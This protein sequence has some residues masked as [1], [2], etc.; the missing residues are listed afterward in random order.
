M[1]SERAP[2]I[3][4]AKA[5]GANVRSECIAKLRSDFRA[6]SHPA[7][8]ASG[9]YPKRPD[10]ASSMGKMTQVTLFGSRKPV[11]Q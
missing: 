2:F 7:K 11:A 1:E 8:N 10:V 3:T 5:A 9:T 6:L 4:Y